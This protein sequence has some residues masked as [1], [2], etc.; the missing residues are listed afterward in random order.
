MQA[1]PNHTDRMDREVVRHAIASNDGGNDLDR[2][3]AHRSE[4]ADYEVMRFW[5]STFVLFMF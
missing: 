4:L 5:D 1:G 2:T 3:Q